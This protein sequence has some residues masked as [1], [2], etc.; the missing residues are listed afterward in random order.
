MILR[1]QYLPGLT[2]GHFLL[3]DI[4]AGFCHETEC[5][6]PSQFPNLGHDRRNRHGSLR[7]R[8]S[9]QWPVLDLAACYFFPAEHG[10]SRKAIAQG[11]IR[12]KILYEST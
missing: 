1:E 9:P 4:F 12:A 6:P 2:A 5:G 3:E 7:P 8:I 11:C 10:I